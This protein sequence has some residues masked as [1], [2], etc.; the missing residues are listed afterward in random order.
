MTSHKL[1]DPKSFES[2]PTTPRSLASHSRKP[3]V[4]EETEELGPQPTAEELEMFKQQ[5]SQWSK[6]DDQMR[7]LSVA[8]RERRVQ[9][10]ALGS[11]IQEFMIKYKYDNLN[12]NG[13]RIRSTVREV[14]QPF[15]LREVKEKILQIGGEDIASRVFDEENRPLVERRSLRRIVPKVSLS[16]DI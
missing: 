7:K 2:N 5:V 10:K 13:S 9:Q 12:T 6:L 1:Y 11:R 14:K 16:L 15:S 3:V 8:L 4:E